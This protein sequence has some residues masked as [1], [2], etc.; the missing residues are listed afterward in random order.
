MS[1]G[2]DQTIGWGGAPLPTG[3]GDMKLIYSTTLTSA[4]NSVTTGTLSTGFKS[5][6]INVRSRSDRANSNTSFSAV[7]FNGDTNASSYQI[8]RL[9][10][11]NAVSVTTLAQD[12]PAIIVMPSVAGDANFFGGAIMR[13]FRPESTTGFK[14]FS[15]ESGSHADDNI[16]VSQARR[17]F[18]YTG[19]WRNTAAI[20]SITFQMVSTQ[21]DSTLADWEAGSSFEV[22]GLK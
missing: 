5:Y 22:Y 14:S 13:V 15:T 2:S 8:M 17:N 6:L 9:Y 16:N 18:Y 19:V 7:Y 4:A 3:E 20:T 10:A 12:S 21:S 1:W 11:A